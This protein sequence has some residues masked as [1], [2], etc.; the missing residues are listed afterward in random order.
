MASIPSPS[1]C[2]DRTRLWQNQHDRMHCKNIYIL[3]PN[4]IF[5]KYQKVTGTR[6]WNCSN[7]LTFSKHRFWSAFW[8]QIKLGYMP[9]WQGSLLEAWHFIQDADRQI[10]ETD[11]INIHQKKSTALT[12]LFKSPLL[13]N[14]LNKYMR[15]SLRHTQILQVKH[16]GASN[17][18]MPIHIPFTSVFP[19]Q[20]AR[21]L[22]CLAR[23]TKTRANR[24]RVRAVR[25]HFIG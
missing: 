8:L 17:L 21:V 3:F 25:E 11:Q 24:I 2:S 4:L 19:F 10:W 12:H 9:S 5:S 1:N 13:K 7:T 15:E 16:I 22:S 18:L 14:K 6:K 20:S 23:M